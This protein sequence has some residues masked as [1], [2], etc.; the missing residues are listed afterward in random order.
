M[1]CPICRTKNSDNAIYCRSCQTPLNKDIHIS[2]KKC[3]QCGKTYREDVKYCIKCQCELV[4]KTGNRLP[5]I[6]I[7]SAVAVFL[8]VSG[9]V[10]TQI[11]YPEYTFN[12]VIR[13]NNSGQLVSV[14]RKHKNLLDNS[15]TIGKYN[16][17]VDKRTDDYINDI[18]SYDDIVVDFENFREINSYLLDDSVIE[19]TESKRKI[20]E[21][22]HESRVFFEK[23]EDMFN[24]KTY[25]T[26][27]ENY[28]FVKEKDEKYY[29]L[30]QDRLKEIDELKMS[31]IRRSDEKISVND[32][33]GSIK[34]LTDGI[35]DFGYDEIYKVKYYNAIVDTIS[36]QS[37]YLMDKGMYF[38][39]DGEKGAFNIVYSYLNEEMYADNDVLKSKLSEIAIESESVEIANAEK[40]LCL[41]NK[42]KVLDRCADVSA[43]DYCNDRSIQDDNS[44][45]LSLCKNDDGVQELL[46]NIPDDKKVSVALISD[47]AMTAEDFS[48]SC[49]DKIKAYSDYVWD[50][51]GIGRYYDEQ[52]KEFSW[53][54]IIIYEME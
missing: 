4:A 26:A 25:K 12:K 44:Y 52:N 40:K 41:I 16:S 29:M 48:D 27:E 20:I 43:E 8:I 46:V 22:F 34:E 11:I 2:K 1:R 21:E 17:F 9:V 32:Y 6:I 3:P 18:I 54:V 47:I 14:C 28:S 49:R 53:A 37:D 10:G 36:R 19:N 13:D 23:A 24:K 39:N 31:Y 15:R 42:N 51:T 50:Y 38:S 30:A 5:V 33:D 35:T 7:S 45:I